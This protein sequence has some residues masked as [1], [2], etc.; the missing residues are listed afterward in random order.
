MLTRIDKELNIEI[1]TCEKC[2]TEWA[3]QE[4]IYSCDGCH[5]RCECCL[6]CDPTIIRDCDEDGDELS[7]GDDEWQFD[8][9][10]NW[11]DQFSDND[12]DLIFDDEEEEDEPA[13]LS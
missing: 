13:P 3:D 9:P 2:G 12:T 8:A 1:F 5:A 7:D 6:D 10:T 4:A 11:E